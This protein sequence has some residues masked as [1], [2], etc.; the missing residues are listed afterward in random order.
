MSAKGDGDI[1][2]VDV[3]VALKDD[4]VE[5]VGRR[6]GWLLVATSAT[7]SAFVLILMA[8]FTSE[9]YNVVGGEC[10]G[11]S[12]CMT[13][14]ENWCKVTGCDAAGH[15]MTGGQ[16][17]VGESVTQCPVS[18]C[19]MCGSVEDFPLWRAQLI[20][21]DACV[22][23][24]KRVRECLPIKDTDGTLAQYRGP[25]VANALAGQSGSE[26]WLQRDAWLDA[27]DAQEAYADRR[28]RGGKAV[29]GVLCVAL[30]L[31]VFITF[32]TIRKPNYA[33]RPREKVMKPLT[34]FFAKI[35]FND[36]YHPDSWW[37]WFATFMSLLGFVVQ[38]YSFYTPTT[39]DT[40]IPIAQG[41]W[42]TLE[43]ITHGVLILLDKFTVSEASS[44]FFDIGF[45]IVGFTALLE[46]FFEPKIVDKLPEFD[47]S[48][49][50]YSLAIRV[51]AFTFPLCMSVKTVKDLYVDNYWPSPATA[52]WI[53]EPKRT[54]RRTISKSVVFAL[55]IGAAV[56][57]YA[58]MSS[59]RYCHTFRT[60]SHGSC[61]PSIPGGVPLNIDVINGNLA[62]KHQ[63]V[64]DDGAKKWR[65]QI[66]SQTKLKFTRVNNALYADLTIE[67][68]MKGGSPGID[69]ST[70]VNPNTNTYWKVDVTVPT[71][72][73]STRFRVECQE[74][75]PRHAF[76]SLTG[77]YEW[78]N[79]NSSMYK[80]V[81]VHNA[82]TTSGDP[83]CFG[84]SSAWW[85]DTE[86]FVGGPGAYVGGAS[87]DPDIGFIFMDQSC[88]T[89]GGATARCLVEPPF[90]AVYAPYGR[91]RVAISGTYQQWSGNP[92]S[93][94]TSATGP[95]AS[96]IDTAW[97]TSYRGFELIM[98]EAVIAAGATSP[99]P[100]GPGAPGPGA[101][102]PGPGVPPMTPSPCPPS[103][104]LPPIG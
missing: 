46:P 94:S 20:R 93:I 36:R 50:D 22:G 15:P 86:N 87:A 103:G 67:V 7:M 34:G 47:D 63:M 24:T 74:V 82:E 2:S 101:P 53:I 88:T 49:S 90:V 61:T 9:L 37:L 44:I 100:S 65:W 70:I 77:K 95:A 32:Y 28:D 60:C 54:L 68:P 17:F 55:Q 96:A 69:E 8:Y 19:S 4:V 62:Y 92:S 48:I 14:K 23:R 81:A 58:M 99:P 11:Y 16:T 83:T 79:Y 42:I 89:F 73:C 30:I 40:R 64:S 6:T 38:L 31:W 72:A 80:F 45:S 66:N 10:A 57:V 75:N 102:G 21:Y 59:K 39:T 18:G 29:L 98:N 25:K 5:R 97:A 26:A 3:E 85:T 43:V 51:L 84:P 104:C 76:D 33:K 35:S 27:C 91:A 56:S 52:M 78:V 71:V 41:V 12:D 1:P 13:M